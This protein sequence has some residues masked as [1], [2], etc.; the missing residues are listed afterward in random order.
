MRMWPC[1]RQS[2]PCSHRT[3]V[4]MHPDVK[5]W[6]PRLAVQA[7]GHLDDA[8]FQVLSRLMRRLPGTGRE[9]E[10]RELDLEPP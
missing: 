3:V 8:P 6:S 1:E 10:G 2:H 4:E 5:G 9:V 7:F